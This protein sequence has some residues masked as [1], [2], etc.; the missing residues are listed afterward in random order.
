MQKN[1]YFR[2][3][4]D[5]LNL[6]SPLTIAGPCSA[7]TQEQILETA[8]QISK[9]TKIDFF[10]AGIWKPRT[11]PGG[12]EGIGEMGLQW[13]QEVR[14]TTG[15]K[16]ATEI[17][18]PYHAELALKHDIDL[19]WIGARTSVSPFI[20]QEIAQALQGTDK[21]ILVKNPVNPDLAL[22][23]G[24]LERLHQ[25]NI[26]KL[27]AIH[28]GFSSYQKTKYRNIPEWQIPIELK[29]LFPNLPLIND[30]SHISGNRDFVFQ[31][32]QT[33]LDLNFDGLMIETHCNPEKAWSDAPQQVTPLRLNNILQKLVVRN[34]TSSEEDYQQKINELRSEIDNLD[35]QLLEVLK[36]RM[37]LSDEIGTLKKNKNI[38]VLQNE[39]WEKI[40]TNMTSEGKTKGIS[41]EFIEKIFKT[42]HQ[43]SINR[44]EEILLT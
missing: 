22:W 4:L 23:I 40:L 37:E 6:S 10:R 31:I 14:N 9:E 43:E 3:W 38:A 41:P 17:A 13:L 39:R 36:K 34:V 27:G 7:E 28:R 33:A 16:I 18:N 24:A 19:L 44:Q 12:F 21:I 8:L 42:I 35:A 20:V 5:D 2:S 30:P 11:R 29:K 1:T 32:A 25:A 15:L 26:T